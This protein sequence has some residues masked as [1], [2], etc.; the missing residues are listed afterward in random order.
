MYHLLCEAGCFG[1]FHFSRTSVLPGKPMTRLATP[2][3]SNAVV[4]TMGTGSFE[5]EYQTL[6]VHRHSALAQKLNVFL[7][8]STAPPLL[9]IFYP[10]L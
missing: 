10:P 8:F 5:S 9:A 3:V 2:L 7:P 4:A 6:F 1:L